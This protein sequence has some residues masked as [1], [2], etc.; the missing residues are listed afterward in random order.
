MSKKRY[1]L[2]DDIRKLPKKAFVTIVERADAFDTLIDNRYPPVKVLGQEIA[3]SDVL[4]ECDYETYKRAVK[5]LYK[6][7]GWVKIHYC[8]WGKDV[9]SVYVRR[10]HFDKSK[11][12]A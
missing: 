8:T 11:V 4:I 6:I 9:D 1:M 2:Y 7:K 12:I 10:E 5:I 3:M